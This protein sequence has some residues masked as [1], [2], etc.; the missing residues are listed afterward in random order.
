[1]NMTPA[2]LFGADKTSPCVRQVYGVSGS[3]KTVFLNHMLREASKDRSFGPMWRAV[4]FDVKHSG[5]EDLVKKPTTN[6]METIR[7]MKK[8]KI[9]VVHPDIEEAQSSLDAIIN[10][11]FGLAQSVEDF[12]GVLI[13]EESS[14]YIR[15]TVGGIPA[16]I[17]RFATQGR[18]LGLSLLLVN[19]R[20][21]SN[22]W[23]DSQ[24]N[25]LTMFR[26]PIPDAD[27]LKKKWGINGEEM[28]SKLAEKP[29]SFAH[30]DLESLNISYYNPIELP[31]PTLK[32]V[33]GSE[34]KKEAKVPKGP[35]LYKWLQKMT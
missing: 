4:V 16:S 6:H 14:T 33:D 31:P 21:L 1:M 19:Q 13:I 5:Y 23:T 34:K 24:S 32:P 12:T 8:H 15:S 2:T 11:M 7:N 35:D 28:N 26:Q 29:F 10:H 3:G 9:T 20:S 27:A 22:R 25:S 30:F 18:S 17:K